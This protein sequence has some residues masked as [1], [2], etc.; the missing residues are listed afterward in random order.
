SKTYEQQNKFKTFIE[1]LRQRGI[2]IPI[3]HLNNSAGIM[4]FDDC[5]DM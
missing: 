1:M 3:K 4:H 5:F 2:E